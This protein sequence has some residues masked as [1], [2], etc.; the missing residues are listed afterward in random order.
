MGWI[1]DGAYAHEGWVANVLADGRVARG[2]PPA[3]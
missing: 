2:A 1:R 3:G